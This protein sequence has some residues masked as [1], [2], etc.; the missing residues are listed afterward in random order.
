[1]FDGSDLACQIILADRIQQVAQHLSTAENAQFQDSLEEQART[2]VGELS[3]AQIDE[4]VVQGQAYTIE[5]RQRDLGATAVGL[6]ELVLAGIKG[7]VAYTWHALILARKVTAHIESEKTHLEHELAA[8]KGKDT[9]AR[10]HRAELRAKIADQVA[11]LEFWHSRKRRLLDELCESLAFLAQDPTDSKALLDAAVRVGNTNLLAMELLEKG[12]LAR[13]GTPSPTVVRIS[14]APGKCILVSGHDLEVLYEL[15]LAT[16]GKGVNVYTH[17]EMLP[18][19]SYPVFRDFDHL[20]GHFGGSWSSQQKEFG[21]FPGAILM[22]SNCIQTP[23]ESYKDYI[24]SIDPVG[25]PGI[26][27]I[28]RNDLGKLDFSPLIKAAQ[29]SSGF[30]KARTNEKITIGYGADALIKLTDPIR[31]AIQQNYLRRIFLIGGCDGHGEKRNYF[32]ELAKSLP[33]DCQILTLGCGKFRFNR[34]EIPPLASGLPRLLDMGQC[35]DAY[36][37][38][39][40]ARFLSEAFGCKISQLPLSI[41]LSWYEQK[42]VA[43]LLSLLALDVTGIRLGPS[44]P[45]FLTPEALSLLAEKFNI[46][47]TT[48]PAADIAEE[49]G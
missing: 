25:Y 47:A 7:T 17:G 41:V 34:E 42:A 11:L 10:T 1:N 27:K 5:A 15:L 43:V 13:F 33:R 20:V 16:R 49:L 21:A 18:A 23:D 9:K 35:N 46:K 24:F 38:I 12:H 22:T 45:A 36:G 37:A 8:S 44:L 29:D 2:P 3:Q 6:Q 31:K 4:L 28:T 19:H 30:F 39:R 40:L 32:T 26:A 14:P 48:T